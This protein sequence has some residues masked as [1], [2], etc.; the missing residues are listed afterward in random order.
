MSGA[1]ILLAPNVLARLRRARISFLFKG[2]SF[3][4]F[5]MHL[6]VANGNTLED[7]PKD[8][9]LVT[10]GINPSRPRLHEGH[11]LTL[12]QACRLLDERRDAKGLVFIDDREFDNKKTT[13]E[14]G[15][16]LPPARNAHDIEGLIRDFVKSMM[17]EMGSSKLSERVDIRRMSRHI[18]LRDGAEGGNNGFALYRLIADYRSTIAR[19]FGVFSHDPT[20]AGLSSVRPACD[21][22]GKG[23]REEQVKT[24]G[25]EYVRGSCTEACCSNDTYTV[26]IRRGDP[27][28]CMHYTIDPLRDVVLSR[29]RD[30]GFAHILGGDYGEPW[31]QKGIPKASRL[32]STI[33]TIA[34]DVTVHHYT[35]PL[36]TRNGEKISKSNGDRAEP[37]SVRQLERMLSQP[38]CEL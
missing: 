2:R 20:I 25:H 14:R 4:T 11:Y 6:S 36:L 29:M 33:D 5:L 8:I 27:H 32:S 16:Y 35:G 23:A 3:F 22:C 21:L 15:I 17:H 19:N 28:W 37:P 7:I 38:T 34:P 18:Q 10:M 12:F 31:G 13:H 30:A 9:D 1:S 24:Y 26:S